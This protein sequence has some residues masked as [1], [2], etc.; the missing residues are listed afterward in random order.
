MRVDLKGRTK[1]TP[2]KF[3]ANAPKL[4][5]TAAMLLGVEMWKRSRSILATTKLDRFPVAEAFFWG[6][7]DLD[8]EE[9]DFRKKLI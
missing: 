5:A 6:R 3:K 9:R 7:F 4:K 8:Q 2:P 1:N